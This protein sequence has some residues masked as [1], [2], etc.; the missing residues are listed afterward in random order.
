MRI[1][2]ACEF[3][4]VVR[5]AFNARAG[6]HAVSC[7]LLPCEDGRPDF[8]RMGDVRDILRDGW[9]LM[10]AHPP[11]TYL[12]GSGLHWNSRRPGR[13]TQTEAALLFVRELLDAPIDRIALEN[14]I[15]CISSRIRPPEQIIQ[16]HQ[17]GHDA[18]KQTRLWLKNLPPLRPTQL[19]APRLV[20]GRKRWS[21]QTDSG[22]NKL[23]PSA[24]RW[25]LRAM[26]YTGIAQAMA[27]QW[28]NLPAIDPEL[29]TPSRFEALKMKPNHSA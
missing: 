22:Q 25:K 13:A 4:G 11:C 15:G 14:P 8:H 27:D 16:P 21:N 7:D 20:N 12:C 18:S 3:S 23:P 6:C 28:T 5:E 1:L 2:I 10:I 19:I 29:F 24:D 26:T 9:D 17:F